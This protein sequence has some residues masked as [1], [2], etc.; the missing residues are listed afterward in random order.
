MS[1]E[2]PQRQ[3][4]DVTPDADL[5]AFIS[6]VKQITE[7]WAKRH[8]LWHD[9]CHKDPIEHYNDELGESGPILLLCSDGPIVNVF[10][11]DYEPAQELSDELER[12]GVYLEH[13]DRVT[14]C[15]HLIDESSDL[16]KRFD[17]FSRW[18]WICKLVEADTADVSGDLYQ[19]FAAHP[20]DVRRL[21]P[22][23][24]EKL[25]S[26]IFAA[27]GWQTELGPGSGDGGVDLRIWQRDPLG[28]LLTLVQVK[29][30]S[31]KRPIE[32]DAVAALEAHVNREG[33][34]RGLFITSSRYLPGVQ[35]FAGRT[36]HRMQL[37]DTSDL[38]RWCQAA[39]YEA[40]VAR[41][42]ALAMESFAPLIEEIRRV[43]SHPR[44]VVAHK[45]GP[46]FC[47]VLRETRTSALLAHIPSDRVSGDIERGELLPLLNGKTQDQRFG[48]T[49]FRAT[50]TERD[51]C[52]SY[53]GQRS[54]YYVW[55][56]KPCGYDHWD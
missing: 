25:V 47:I 51:G 11:W 49:V 13:E 3:G 17:E 1:S 36:K 7:A 37:A 21:P 23:D 41:N 33:A 56:G 50:R 16:Q 4:E 24:F 15:Y 9:S 30:Y 52:V 6:Q 5:N 43:G 10:E 32:L 19:H 14:S 22:R 45:F 53:W 34:N 55:D 44:L 31:P 46:S 18:K 29:R 54:L 26:S 39:A 12:V 38:Q 20:D 48:D 42:R 35:H 8:D 40:T 27:R 2:E 28:D